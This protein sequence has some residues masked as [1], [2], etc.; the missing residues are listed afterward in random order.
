MAGTLKG[1]SD[2]EDAIDDQIEVWKLLTSRAWRVCRHGLCAYDG[3]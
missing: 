3:A 2:P 1:E